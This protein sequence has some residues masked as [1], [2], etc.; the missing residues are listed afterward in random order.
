[1][2]KVIK[3]FVYLTAVVLILALQARA[4][5]LTS[6]SAKLPPA[7][8]AFVPFISFD[9]GDVYKG[10]IISHIFVI[11]NE[12][13]ADLLIKDFV[14]GCGCELVSADKVIPPGKEGKAQIEVNT[15]GQFGQISKPATLHTNDPERLNIVLTLMANVLTSSDGGPV[16]GVA[17]RQGKHIGPIFLGPEVRGVF[18]VAVGQK[19]KMEFN[20]WVEKAPLKVLRLEGDGKY[21][22]TRLETVEE[23]KKYKI[24]VEPLSTENAGSYEEVLRVVT[25]SPALPSVPIS[26]YLKVQPKQ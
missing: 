13:T 16:K 20:V 8:H 4:Q 6:E 19:S 11:K 12:G 2:K 26:L 24:T 23:G 17:L 25:D 22:T 9:F 7:P 21:F 14:G 10:E 18:H 15:A 1:M 3:N 5:Q